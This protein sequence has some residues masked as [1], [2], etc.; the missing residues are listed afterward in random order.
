MSIQSG[1]H[2]HTRN[3]GTYMRAGRKSCYK[4]RNSWQGRT[5]QH[6]ENPFIGYTPNCAT[7]THTLP[8][9]C[10]KTQCNQWKYAWEQ[11]VTHLSDFFLDKRKKHKRCESALNKHT[12]TCTVR[13]NTP[14][15]PLWLGNLW[16]SA[17]MF[18][19]LILWGPNLSFS[20][21]TLQFG[22]AV[23]PEISIGWLICT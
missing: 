10:A 6:T 11:L 7:R 12:H 19:V 20:A 9:S 5:I 15:L 14:K 18:Q 13:T 23:G 1:P 22:C 16:A 17:S 2:S 8:C 21:A 3:E 4:Y